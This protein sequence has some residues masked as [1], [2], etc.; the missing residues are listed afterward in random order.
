MNKPKS[1]EPERF[2]KA[3]EPKL[4]LKKFEKKTIKASFHSIAE[5]EEEEKNSPY[6]LPIDSD[7]IRGSDIFQKY[8][9]SCHHLNSNSKTNPMRFPGIGNVYGRLVGADAYFEYSKN[10][11]NISFRWNKVNLFEFIKS[12]KK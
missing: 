7:P 6:T 3:E 9:G 1:K 2:S 12:P 8:C 4:D 10:Y 11:D 5:A